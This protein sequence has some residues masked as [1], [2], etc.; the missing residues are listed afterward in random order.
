[1]NQYLGTYISLNLLLNKH[2]AKNKS[3]SLNH[4]GDKCDEIAKRSI[5]KNHRNCSPS[6]LS[7]LGAYSEADKSYSVNFN[8]GYT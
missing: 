8:G 1:M 7:R 5:F 2:I 3:L 6:E 4:R